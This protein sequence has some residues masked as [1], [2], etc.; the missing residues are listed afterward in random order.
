MVMSLYPKTQT[1]PKLAQ[2]VVKLLDA[3]IGG[4]DLAEGLEYADKLSGLVDLPVFNSSTNPNPSGV[5]KVVNTGDRIMVVMN[6]RGV[7]VPYYIST[8]QGGKASVPTGKWYPVFGVHSSGWLNKGGEDSINKFYGS[9]MLALNAGRL[10]NALGDLSSVEAQIP[11]MKKTGFAIINKDLQP[12]GHSEVSAN[13][14]AF[15]ERVNSFLAKLGE[16]PY[17]TIDKP[18]EPGVAEGA[19]IVVAQAPIDVRNPKKQQSRQEKPLTAYQQGVASQGKPYKNPYPFDPKAGADVNYDHN[20]YRAGY[21]KQGVTE[22][23]YMSLDD[24]KNNLQNALPSIIEYYQDELG[25]TPSKEQL[26]S[27]VKAAHATMERTG[28]TEQAGESL[29]AVLDSFVPSNSSNKN[30]PKI[31]FKKNLLQVLQ[32][33]YPTAEFKITPDRVE[34]TDGQLSVIADTAQEGRYVGCFMWDVSTG[35]YKGALGLAI[36]QTTDQLL[37][38]NPG[39]KPALFISGDNQNPEAWS[40]IAKKLKYKLITDENEL[41]ENQGWAATYEEVRGAPSGAG[42]GMTAGY[43]RRENQP[44]DEDYIDEK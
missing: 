41:E 44:I 36:K 39:K 42:A 16:G 28:D 31:D 33:K 14:N 5:A 27:A 37:Q 38:A 22:A 3:A 13:P 4:Q 24:Y 1:N 26:A 19:P 43:Q 9:K 17:Y 32:Q 6:V 15:K 23:S 34:S 40:Y 29:E 8:G 7:N 10:N 20:Q 35:P 21:K 30:L 12:M 11:F 25:F 2:T 18:K